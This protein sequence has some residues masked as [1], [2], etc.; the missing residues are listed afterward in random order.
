MTYDSREVFN[1]IKHEVLVKVGEKY[2]VIGDICTQTLS[3]IILTAIKNKYFTDQERYNTCL[4]ASQF[5]FQF[6]PLLTASDEMKK[7]LTEKF[8]LFKTTEVIE[9]FENYLVKIGYVKVQGFP[10]GVSTYVLKN[11]TKA[12][13]KRC[14]PFVYNESDKYFEKKVASASLIG[15]VILFIILTVVYMN[16]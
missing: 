16:S 3:I 6:S 4:T 14:T 1:Y 8:K 9:L 15:V 10:F 12:A 13:P 7:E 5:I 11:P 2:Q